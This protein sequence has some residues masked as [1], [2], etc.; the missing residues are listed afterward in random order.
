MDT[1]LQSLLYA[2]DDHYLSD[3]DLDR[4]HQ[5]IQSLA[6]RIETY[7][8]LR[9][10]ELAILQP[11]ADYLSEEFPT[12]DPKLLER[13]VIHWINILRYSAMAMLLNDQAFLSQRILEWMPDLVQAYQLQDIEK[14]LYRFLQMQLKNSLSPEQLNLLKPYLEEAHATLLSVTPALQPAA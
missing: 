10:R 9:D 5:D 7:E 6:E 11:T 13:S 12:A 8:T 3:A 2:A 1:A 4:F 14:T